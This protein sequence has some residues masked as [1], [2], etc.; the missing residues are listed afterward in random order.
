MPSCPHFHFSH[1]ISSLPCL[2]AFR[3][4]DSFNSERKK[5]K[6]WQKSM[7]YYL[8]PKERKTDYWGRGGGRAGARERRKEWASSIIKARE[9]RDVAFSPLTF[10]SRSTAHLPN[11]T[12]TPQRVAAHS[13]EVTHVQ[14]TP[15]LLNKEEQI[16]SETSS[17]PWR[18][19]RAPRWALEHRAPSGEGRWPVENLLIDNKETANGVGGLGFSVLLIIIIIIIIIT[20]TGT[21]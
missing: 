19:C 5:Y 18:R 10:T 11:P 6:K 12:K 15:H 1:F 21:R 14:K 3:K 13:G 4:K 2:L 16:I 20:W 9:G 8:R 7:K 17:G